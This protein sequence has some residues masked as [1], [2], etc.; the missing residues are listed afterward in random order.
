MAN[1]AA[2]QQQPH[3]IFV[4]NLHGNILSSF[5]PDKFSGNYRDARPFI[6][7]FIRYAQF[8][9][10][11]DNQKCQALALLLNNPAPQAWYESLDDQ[12][13]NDWDELLNAFRENYMTGPHVALQRRIASYSNPQNP[14]ENV[15]EYINR[16]LDNMADLQYDLDTKVSLLV[17]G[18][19]PNLRSYG[20]MALPVANINE[21]KNKL[22]SAELAMKLAAPTSVVAAIETKNEDNKLQDRITALEA[23][24]SAM[25]VNDGATAPRPTPRFQGNTSYDRRPRPFNRA[26]LRCFICDSERHL[27]RECPFGEDS[28]PQ[29]PQRQQPQSNFYG[30]RRPMSNYPSR[31]N[32]TSRFRPTGPPR[33]DRPTYNDRGQFRQQDRTPQFSRHMNRGR[34]FSNMP[35][36]SYDESNRTQGNV[37]PLLGRPLN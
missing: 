5:R 10:L 36:R 35:R 21:F 18:L 29:R 37:R 30:N 23:N 34:G 15:V 6:Q 27:F 2:N 24:L 26:P 20:I 9:N 17:Q 7:G 8:G 33:Y 31:D 16:A 11:N 14:K 1:P 32:P 25:I 4:N 22:M 19:H 12:V 13:K 28:Y 3:N